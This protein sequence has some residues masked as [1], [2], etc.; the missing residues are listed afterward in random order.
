M[1]IKDLPRGKF[2][3]KQYIFVFAKIFHEIILLI[4]KKATAMCRVYV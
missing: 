2:M 3:D 1:Q 4:F